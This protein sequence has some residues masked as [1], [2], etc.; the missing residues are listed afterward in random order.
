MRSI[1]DIIVIGAGSAGLGVSIAMRRLGLSVLLINR[2]ERHIG[3]DCLNDGCVPSKALLH[4]SKQVH[5]ARQTAT[6]GLNISGNVDLARVMQYVRQRQDVIRAHEN[7]QYL[8]DAESLDVEIGTAAFAGPTTISLN[9]QEVSAKNIVLCT[10]SKPHILKA[11]GVEKVAVLT[12]KSLSALD[13]LPKHL[14]IVG[15][16]P[17]GIEMAQAFRRLGSDVTV[18]DHEDRILSKEPPPASLLLQERLAG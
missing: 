7:A 13:T 1:Y 16:G 12:H 18:V 10:G 6:Y 14:L 4:V 15:A 17:N 2:D 8:R 9:G 3:G 11:D 5:Q